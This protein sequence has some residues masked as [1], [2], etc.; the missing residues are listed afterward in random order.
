MSELTAKQELATVKAL[1]QSAAAYIIGL[2]PR[3]FR[4]LDAPRND[5]G[6]YNAAELVKWQV[7]RTASPDDPLLAGGDSPNLERYRKAKA[8]LAEMDAAERRGQLADV[9]ALCEWWLIEVAPLVR[10]AIDD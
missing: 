4:D 7:A 1:G 3:S 6:T 10:Q 9:N 2:K 5:D 8:E